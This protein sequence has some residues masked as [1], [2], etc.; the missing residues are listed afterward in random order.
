MVL[1]KEELAWAER[2][3]TTTNYIAAAAIYLRDNFLLERTLQKKDIKDALLGHWGTCPGINFIYTHL[4]LLAFKKEQQILLLV[5]PGHGFAAVL[6]H[7]YLEGSLQKY[8]PD[9]THDAEGLGRVIKSFCWPEGFP[10]HLNPG[11]PGCIHEGGELGYALGTAFG[12]AFDNPDLLVAAIIGDGEAETGPTATAWH[13]TKFLNAA[14]DGAVLPILHLNGYK[15]NS[16]S[17]YGTMSDS[18][19]RSLF[20]GYG[21]TPFFVGTSHNEMA[22]ALEKSHALIQEI[23]QKARQKRVKRTPS[24]PMIIL[25]TP[26]GWTGIKNHNGERIEGS[27]RSHQVPIKDPK[28]NQHSLK[29]IEHWLR[30]YNPQKLFPQG[31]VDASLM[32]FVPQGAASIGGNPHAIGGD[33]RV[34]LKLPDAHAYAVKVK[35]PGAL[36]ASSTANFAQYLTEVMV[37]NSAARNFRIMSPDEL[38]SN[39]LDAVLR[40]TNRAYSWPHSNDDETL[41]PEG[42]VMEM[43]SEHTLQSW[44]QGYVLTG[45]HGIFP[46]YEAFL[47]IVDSMVSQYLKFITT[48]QEYPW[49]TPVSA[50]N[51][52][53]TSVCWRQD[54]NGFSHQ[55]PGFITTLLNKAREE[56]LVRLYFPADA[57][58]FLVV[59]EHIL[60]STNRVNVV[61]ADKQIIRQ[62][63]SY[64]EAVKQAKRGAAIWDF[65]SNANPDI[66]LA[67]CGDYQTQEMLAAISILKTSLP[68][69]KIR[70]VNVSELNVLGAEGVY[71]NALSELAFNQLFTSDREVIFAFHGYPSA[72]KQILFDRVKSVDLARFSTT[73]YIES[74]T[75]T[76]PFDMLVR[77][78]VSRYHFII[79]AATR[80]AKQNKAIASKTAG[81]VATC[82]KKLD[83]HHAYI[84]REGHDPQEIN[85][86]QWK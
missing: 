82:K 1:K 21:Y 85:D 66:V 43:L 34:Q 31:K 26:K 62:W 44:L 67:A 54:H 22:S 10:S 12:A 35:K 2:Y 49:R 51:Y 27:Y 63:L 28:T 50:L 42:R 33:K 56:Q 24:W 41:A 80:G 9:L 40:V 15:I 11:V 46:S 16:P 64:D 55:N 65:A 48:S 70:F 4:N 37:Q 19:L 13:S 78:G 79:E 6:A 77:N 81:L 5:G 84:V 38:A 53:L 45:R 18:E 32:R 72:I 60:Q 83:E 23:K 71:P 8:Y 74:G 17:I 52:I 14:G 75:T 39:R 20:I 3:W 47:P 29:E 30:K 36:T 73:G 59:G 68:E 57:N 25:K 61:V 86:W 7:L 76:T 69:L 58:M